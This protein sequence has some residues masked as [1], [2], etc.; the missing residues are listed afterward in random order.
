MANL[1]ERRNQVTADQSQEAVKCLA[2]RSGG[3]KPRIARPEDEED[4]VTDFNNLSINH[5]RD[6]PMN[7]IDPILTRE[8]R[9]E[10]CDKQNKSPYKSDRM[11]AWR[12]LMV[13]AINQGLMRDIFTLDPNN[14][15]G[16]T[17]YQFQDDGI[18]YLVDLHPIGHGELRLHVGASFEGDWHREPY[19]CPIQAW[20]WLERKKGKWLQSG[21]HGRE[22][23]IP[24]RWRGALA[25]MEV[26]PQG[27][28][29]NGPIMF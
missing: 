2:P 7:Y 22:T 17:V 9:K 13:M 24:L 14:D 19:D 5:Q 21:G 3:E 29:D 20:G 1:A 6:T 25:A 10:R 26:E 11:R 4:C 28:V 16:S 18:Y 15:P 8:L 23:R 27:F 12:N